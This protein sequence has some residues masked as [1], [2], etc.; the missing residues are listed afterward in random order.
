LKNFSGKDGS[1]PL[2]KIGPY[3]YAVHYQPRGAVVVV[4]VGGGGGAALHE[5]DETRRSA[6][7]DHGV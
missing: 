6:T 1:V 4:I 5:R 2:E 3:A 7:W